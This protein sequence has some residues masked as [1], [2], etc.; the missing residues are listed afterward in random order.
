MDNPSDSTRSRRERR[1][2]TVQKDVQYM[3]L[4]I[5]QD[6]PSERC[7]RARRQ[8]QEAECQSRGRIVSPWEY[9][10]VEPVATARQLKQDAAASFL[11]C[12]PFCS[13]RNRLTRQK[14]WLRTQAEAEVHKKLADDDKSLA[15][16]A[17]KRIFDNMGTDARTLKNTMLLQREELLPKIKPRLALWDQKWRSLFPV[18]EFMTPANLV[19]AANSYNCMHDLKETAKSTDLENL[20][21]G[22]A[23][24]HDDDSTLRVLTAVAARLFS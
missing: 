21:R 4:Q 24:L 10:G 23:L 5:E 19:A 14:A 2:N 22:M 6:S 12:G 1:Y 18:Y 15:N 7:R 13:D 3:T 20:D 9:P 16:C 11:N 17:L 8:S